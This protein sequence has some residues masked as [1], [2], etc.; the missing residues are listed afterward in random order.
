MIE[1]LSVALVQSLSSDYSITDVVEKSKLVDVSEE[2]G[3]IMLLDGFH[4][5]YNLNEQESIFL[6]NL[7]LRKLLNKGLIPQ[8]F[9]FVRDN[10]STYI[11]KNALDNI[12]SLSAS[13]QNM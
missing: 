13:M 9:A 2:Q 6:C 4:N 11:G 12:V 1:H 10:S 8:F 7:F 5:K 3:Q